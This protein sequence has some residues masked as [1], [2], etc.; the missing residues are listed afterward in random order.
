MKLTDLR[1]DTPDNACLS[2]RTIAEKV[3]AG[4]WKLP[5]AALVRGTN[6]GL[7]PSWSF[8]ISEP[9]PPGSLPWI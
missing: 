1:F 2:F 7:P 3:R 6:T 8:I 4:E 9:P 5:E